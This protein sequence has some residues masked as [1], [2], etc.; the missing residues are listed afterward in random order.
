MSRLRL[1][2]LLTMT[3]FA[4]ACGGEDDAAANHEAQSIVIKTRMNLPAGEILDGSMV[5]GSPFC[6]GGTVEDK[7]STDPAVGLAEKTIT[8]QD[9][10]LRMGFDPQVPVGNTQR[11]PWRI[12]SGTGAYEGWSGGGQM[13]MRYDPGDK[14]EHPTRGGERFTGTVEP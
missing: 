6:A 7:H 12:V 9:G 11:G 10:T 13:V 1:A 5:G 14:K 2:A 4:P 8:C 3:A